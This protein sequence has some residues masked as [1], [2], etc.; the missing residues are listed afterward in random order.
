MVSRSFGRHQSPVWTIRQAVS[1][2]ESVRQRSDEPQV[3]P[4]AYQCPDTPS[5][6]SGC[7]LPI[8][9]PKEKPEEMGIKQALVRQVGIRSK[10]IVTPFT[11]KNLFPACALKP[12]PEH[13]TP[14]IKQRS[15]LLCMAHLTNPEGALLYSWCSLRVSQIG[16]ITQNIPRGRCR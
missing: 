12:S 7:H 11:L 15:C 14:D 1:Y 8:V 13:R 5:C 6:D 4:E 9:L 3:V 2:L 10:P 16:R